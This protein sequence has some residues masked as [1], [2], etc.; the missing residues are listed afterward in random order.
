MR[1][2]LGRQHTCIGHILCTG[3]TVKYSIS[4]YDLDRLWYQ[5]MSIYM[6]YMLPICF[7]AVTFWCEEVSK[8]GVEMRFF[9]VFNN[10]A[11]SLHQMCSK[12]ENTLICHVTMCRNTIDFGYNSGHVAL[13]CLEVV[14][15]L[16]ARSSRMQSEQYLQ[17][18]IKWRNTH[19][20]LT[21][22]YCK[23]W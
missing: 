14:P 11:V 3:Q 8:F 21:T 7:L 10:I 6:K 22:W 5:D 1:V 18:F 9:S 12:R 4:C 13:W 2:G 23:V 15:V 16:Y 19:A 17:S 20:Q